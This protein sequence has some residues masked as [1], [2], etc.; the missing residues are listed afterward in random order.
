MSDGIRRLSD[1][2]ARDPSS[3]VFIQLGEELRRTGQLDL[4][5][6]VALRGLER[7]PHD[8][9]AHDLLARIHVDRGELTAAFDEW[10]TVLKLAPDH[11]GARKGVGYVLFKQGRLAEAERYLSQASAQGG[12]DPS[13]ATAL[14]MVRR[15][16]HFSDGV[17]GYVAGAS[18]NGTNGGTPLAEAG[19]RVEEEAR[20]L[21]ADILGEGE[22]TALLLDAS[23][24]VTAGVYMTEEG[25]DVA[26]EVGASLAGIREDAARASEHLG[27]GAW[28]SVTFETDVATV[29]MAPVLDDSLVLVAAARSVP[30][31]LVRRVLQ[32]CARRAGAWLGATS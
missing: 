32:Q 3:L 21:F 1:E 11:A 13:I 27:L 31:G 9:D 19:R 25:R 6:R 14:H 16:L 2:L 8:A 28:S 26:Q 23:G 30:L 22:Q 12:G 5:L 7:H 29:A 20:R 24:L 10:D 4:A 17:G 18:G 15:M